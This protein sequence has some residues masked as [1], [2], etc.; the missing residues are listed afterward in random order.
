MKKICIL[1]GVVLLA[2]CNSSDEKN[3]SPIFGTNLFVTETDVVISDKI[4]AADENN[5]NLMYSLSGQP[6]NGS[7]SLANNGNFVYTPAAEFTGNDSFSVM[8]SDGEFAVFGTV[9]IDVRVANVSFLTYSRMAFNQAETSAPLAING[10]TFIQDSNNTAD[11]ADLL[12]G[13]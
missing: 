5:D 1:L 13:N 9:S 4:R 8:V 11:Y 12:S 7:V 2:G 6:Q 3:A 10:R